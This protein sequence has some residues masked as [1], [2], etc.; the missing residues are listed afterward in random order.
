M[1]EIDRQR[2]SAVNNLHELGL[3]WRGGTWRK[4]GS[5][6]LTAEADA[7]HALLVQRADALEGCGEGS[8]EE[9]SVNHRC[10]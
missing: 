3:G 9:T 10:S 8:P 1:G 4:A 5:P 7:M 2:I 6:D